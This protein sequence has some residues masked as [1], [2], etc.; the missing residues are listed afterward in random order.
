[1]RAED[2]FQRPE[3]RLRKE[4]LRDRTVLQGFLA[5]SPLPFAFRRAAKFPKN[6]PVVVLWTLF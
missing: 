5:P 3:M 1:M 6:V 4:R 2:D